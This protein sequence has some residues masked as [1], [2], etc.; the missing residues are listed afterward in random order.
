MSTEDNIITS[1]ITDNT[2]VR[3]NITEILDHLRTGDLTAICIM[4]RTKD[5]ALRCFWNGDDIILMG[6]LH[7][8]LHDLANENIMT[9]QHF[10]EKN[11]DDNNED[12]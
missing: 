4:W 1:N 12:K 9:D 8:Q 5:K 2:G 7:Q 3:K 6:M 10:Y 11:L